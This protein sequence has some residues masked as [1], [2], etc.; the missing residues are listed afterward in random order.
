MACINKTQIDH[1]KDFMEVVRCEIGYGDAK[2]AGNRASY[3]VLF[4]DQAT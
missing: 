4:I 1:L 2:S 3:C